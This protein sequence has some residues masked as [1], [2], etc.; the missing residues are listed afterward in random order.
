MVKTFKPKIGH[1]MTNDFF[2][3]GLLRVEQ[4]SKRYKENLPPLSIC[5]KNLEKITIYFCVLVNFV[6][7]LH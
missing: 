2:S 4:V 3:F 1:E 6:H 7:F 5:N